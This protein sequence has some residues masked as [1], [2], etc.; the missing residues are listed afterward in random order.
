VSKCEFI[1]VFSALHAV[2]ADASDGDALFG[3]VVTVFPILQHEKAPST[4][5][6]SSQ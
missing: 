2:I 5:K 3:R 4:P 1:V 6:G